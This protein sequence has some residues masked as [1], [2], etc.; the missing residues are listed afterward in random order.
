MQ[1]FSVQ[2]VN[3]LLNRF[4]YHLEENVILF[5]FIILINKIVKIVRLWDYYFLNFVKSLIETFSILWLFDRNR[6]KSHRRLFV[7]LIVCKT[8]YTYLKESG[9]RK[10]RGPKTEQQLIAPV[11]PSLPIKHDTDQKCSAH[12]SCKL[13]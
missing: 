12:F 9:V 3:Y 7:H 1:Q 13:K 6:V 10:P 8:T 2:P 5:N 11:G 4:I